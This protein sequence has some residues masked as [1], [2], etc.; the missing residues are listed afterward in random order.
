MTVKAQDQVTI[1]VNV[2]LSSVEVYYKLQ[3]STAAPPAKPT[4][5]NPSDW[6]TTEPTYDGTSTNTLY[7]CQKT[8]LTN[9]IFMWSAV[10]KSTSY[11]AAKAAW[12]LAHSASQSSAALESL[13]GTMEAPYRQVEWVESDGHQFVATRY[14]ATQDSGFDID[15]ALIDGI[16]TGLSN[17]RG[18]IN[19]A[20]VNVDGTTYTGT[21]FGTFYKGSLRGFGL[22]SN[23]ASGRAGWIMCNATNAVTA[24][25]GI[26]FYEDGRRQQASL[27]NRV[28]TAPNGTTKTLAATSDFITDYYVYVFCAHETATA[29]SSAVAMRLYSL[30]FYDGDIL[31]VDLIPAVRNSDE[32]PGLYD[33][34]EGHFY[35]CG[36]LEF[37]PDTGTDLGDSLTLIESITQENPIIY[38]TRTKNSRILTGEC[39]VLTDMRDG[40]RLTYN[41]RY[42]YAA[43]TAPDY[44]G[45]TG[46]SSNCLIDLTLANSKHVPWGY[47]YYNT[48]TVMT[49]HYGAGSNLGLVYRENVLVGT[50][51]IRCGYFLDANYYNNTNNYDRRLHNDAIKAVVAITAKYLICGTDDGYRHVAAGTAFDLAYPVLYAS[52]AIKI[53]ATAKTA[54]QALPDVPFSTTGTIEGAAANKMLFLKGTVEG[55]IFTIASSPFLTC[56]TPTAEN[57]YFYI[58]LGILTSATAGY[59]STSKDLYAYLDGKFRQVTPTEIVA[60]QR[61]YFRS[62]TAQSTWTMPS[63]WLTED[64]NVYNQ[65]TTK[66]PPLAAST[67]SGE[68]KYLYLYTCE[69]R[70]RLDGTIAYTPVLLDENTTV[71]DGG[72]IVTHSITANQ[73]AANSITANEIDATNLQVAAANVTGQLTATQINT[74]GLT[75]G[76]S[77][78]SNPPSIPSKTSDLTNDSSFATTSQVGTAKNEA[79]NAAATDA[80]SKANAAAKTATNFLTTVDSTGL[81]VHRANNTNSGIKIT[82][83]VDIIRSG[84]SFANYGETTRIGPASDKHLVIDADSFDFI[85]DTTNIA[86]LELLNEDANDVTVNLRLDGGFGDNYLS[87]YSGRIKHDES[88]DVTR[89]DSTLSAH[90]YGTPMFQDGQLN[91][92]SLSARSGAYES[93]IYFQSRDITVVPIKQT[94]I[95]IYNAPLDNFGHLIRSRVDIAW[96]TINV[97]ANSGG[98]VTLSWLGGG[99]IDA[100][101]IAIPG[102]MTGPNGYTKIQ[103]AITARTPTTVTVGYWNDY[104]AAINGMIIG[105]IG[106]D[107]RYGTVV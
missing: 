38:D 19:Q 77:Q 64:G 75:I 40:Q 3:P 56:V 11:E 32:M 33:A 93:D 57:G 80:T 100:N 74:S 17:A 73:I 14:L 62:N 79:I 67:A 49:S 24:N 60:T 9:G 42:T 13:I 105:V 35:P 31:A 22:S 8:T 103:F 82:D 53:N 46:S 21:M 25:G 96:T 102:R 44:P 97:A 54:Y 95:S 50:A 87:A 1:S 16:H 84:T 68:T 26:G 92:T 104:T 76:Y 66:V 41:T 45:T 5:A 37:G 89:L 51:A 20:F 72:Q 10:S 101:Y 85:D 18:S 28:Y 47:V 106:V 58:P 7:S 61:I 86:T 63:A 81:F 71:I 27:R 94:P 55:S 52:A 36:G 39:P 4:T 88:S 30:K 65:W 91:L 34:V 69:Q 78:I 29:T 12:N 15:V 59:F 107:S 90:Y 2:D 23:G 70:K 6:T 43:E 99:F 98:G 48:A 83:N